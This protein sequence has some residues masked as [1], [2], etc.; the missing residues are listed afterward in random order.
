MMH[1]L[2]W[3]GCCWRM[4]ALIHAQERRQCNGDTGLPLCEQVIR[5]NVAVLLRCRA[6]LLEKDGVR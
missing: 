2:S 5:R 6:I 3:P 4:N 1:N